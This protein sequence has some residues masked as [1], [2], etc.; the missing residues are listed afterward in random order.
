MGNCKGAT[1]RDNLHTIWREKKNVSTYW[2]SLFF[3]FC[4][5]IISVWKTVQFFSIHFQY[6]T[7][8]DVTLSAKFGC[9]L[10]FLHWI[11]AR[12]SILLAV[13]MPIKYMSDDLNRFDHREKRF[14]KKK[15][16]FMASKANHLTC[17]LWG[18][19]TSTDFSVNRLI[20][21]G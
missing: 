8:T 2:F 12:R 19:L 15:K 6:I 4:T 5:K 7:S 9:D 18:N 21:T 17:I 10:I 16:S 11:F 20:L 1:E 14:E 13:A 3:S